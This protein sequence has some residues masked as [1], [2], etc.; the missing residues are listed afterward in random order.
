M[1]NFNNEYEILHANPTF[2]TH[3][4]LLSIINSYLSDELQTISNEQNINDISNNLFL[5]ERKVKTLE[6]TIQNSNLLKLWSYYLQKKREN[7]KKC[8]YSFLSKF[9]ELKEMNLSEEQI[10][11]L[12]M[13]NS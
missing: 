11:L 12:Y 4:E 13:M 5:M 7:Y 6:G 3:N 9:D 2:Y 1:S 10:I 8:L